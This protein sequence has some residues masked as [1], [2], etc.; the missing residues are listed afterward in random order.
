MCPSNDPMH[1]HSIPGRIVKG[2]GDAGDFY[3]LRV[4]MDL[5]VE[6]SNCPQERNPCNGF[7]PTPM[8][9]IIYE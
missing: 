8:G 1:K 5:L 3:D 2:M 9:V 6:L 4:E 7:N